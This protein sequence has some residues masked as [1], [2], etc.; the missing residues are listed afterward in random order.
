MLRFIIDVF[1]KDTAIGLSQFDDARSSRIYK[2]SHF[3]LFRIKTNKRF[4]NFTD[5]IACHLF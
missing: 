5:P 3:P 2:N 4:L 1:C